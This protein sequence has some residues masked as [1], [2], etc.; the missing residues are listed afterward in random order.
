MRYTSKNFSKKHKSSESSGVKRT[1]FL[2]ELEWKQIITRLE[3]TKRK[4]KAITFFGY[5]ICSLKKKFYI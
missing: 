5:S 3:H 1:Y 4:V 2:N